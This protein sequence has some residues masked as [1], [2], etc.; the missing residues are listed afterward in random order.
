[1]QSE[2]L[3]PESR[4]EAAR[5][6]LIAVLRAAVTWAVVT[7]PLAVMMLGFYLIEAGI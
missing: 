3:T 2:W 7:S 4:R 5:E 1:M 6:R